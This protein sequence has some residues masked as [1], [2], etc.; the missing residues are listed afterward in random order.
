MLCWDNTQLTR[1][2][3][4][5]TINKWYDTQLTNMLCRYNTQLT[6]C[7][8]RDDTQLTRCYVEIIHN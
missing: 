6:R 2:V 7:C 4:R 1:Y 3:W 8:L 5:D